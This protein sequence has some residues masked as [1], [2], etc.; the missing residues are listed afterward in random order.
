MQEKIGEQF[1]SHPM[2]KLEKTAEA[3]YFKVI[4][5]KMERLFSYSID[6][7]EY[8]NV[9]HLDNVYY[10]CDEGLKKGKRFTGPMLGMYAH[11]GDE[12]KETLYVTYEYFK[13][14]AI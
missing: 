8:Q 7:K 5:V 6:G 10:L 1:I 4:A 2:R 9:V 11:A 13:Y 14:E 3:V 12:A